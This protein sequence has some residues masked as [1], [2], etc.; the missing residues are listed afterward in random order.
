MVNCRSLR[1]Y[2]S[3]AQDTPKICHI[4]DHLCTASSHFHRRMWESVG[5]LFVSTYNLKLYAKNTEQCLKQ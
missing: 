3:R 2:I 5:E 4:S 1:I